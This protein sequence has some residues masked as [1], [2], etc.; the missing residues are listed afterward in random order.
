MSHLWEKQDINWG[1]V[2]KEEIDKTWAKNI[3]YVHNYCQLNDIIVT[4]GIINE[5]E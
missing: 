4:R 3:S 2:T 5:N 1:I